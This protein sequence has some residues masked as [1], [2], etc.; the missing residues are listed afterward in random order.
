LKSK[1]AATSNQ[2]DENNQ[3]LY[4]LLVQAEWQLE[5]E[6]L[7]KAEQEF[8]KEKGPLHWKFWRLSQITLDYLLQTVRSSIRLTTSFGCPP[9]NFTKVLSNHLPWNIALARSGTLLAILTDEVIEVRSHKDS[10]CSVVA[11]CQVGTDPFPQWRRITW[12]KQGSLLALA[13]SFGEMSVFDPSCSLLYK[14]KKP[15]ASMNLPTGFNNCLCALFFVDA[16][17]SSEWEFNLICVT[18]HGVLHRYLLNN[19]S[20]R[21]AH[22]F[23]FS[24]YHPAGVAAVVYSLKHNLLVVAGFKGDEPSLDEPEFTGA[25]AGI[26]LWRELSD[27]PHYAIVKTDSKSHE[28]MSKRSRLKG[29]P[30]KAKDIS[31]HG[32]YK[33]VLS[34]NEDTVVTLHQNG[35]IA[36]WRMPSLKLQKTWSLSE[37]PS[38]SIEINS[39][40]LDEKSH[41]DGDAATLENFVNI[42]WWSEEALICARG[43]GSIAVSSI[44]D[45]ENLLGQ[46]EEMF[47]PWPCTTDAS[48][49]QFLVLECEKKIK[50]VGE[51]SILKDAYSEEYDHDD[52]VENFM[53][54]ISKMCQQ[55]LYFL[56]ENDSF[57]PPSKQIRFMQRIYRLVALQSTTPEELYARKINLEEYGEALELAKRFRLDTDL[58]YQRQWTTSPITVISIK[59]Y[60]S[61]INNRFWVLNECV[62]RVPEDI[63]AM[64]YLLKYGLLGTN[65]KIIKSIEMQAFLPFAYSEEQQEV[66]DDDG[67]QESKEAKELCD[68]VSSLK[69]ESLSEKQIQLCR[70]RWQLLQYLDRLETYEIILGGSFKAAERY[71]PDF[72]L[73]FRCCNIIDQSIEYARTSHSEPLEE[74][75]T[76]HGRDVLPHWLAILSNFPETTPVSSYQRLLPFVRESDS[77]ETI[78]EEWK[79]L[80]HREPDWVEADIIKSHVIEQENEDQSAFIYED[81][82]YLCTYRSCNDADLLTKWFIERAHEIESRASLVDNALSLIEHGIEN[83]IQGLEQTRDNLKWLS[84]LAYE[85]NV[86]PAIGLGEFEKLTDLEKLRLLMSKSIE[87]TFVQDYRKWAS[88]FMT[89]VGKTNPESQWKLLKRYLTDVAKS[90]LAFPLKIFEKSVPGCDEPLIADVAKLM[91]LAIDCIYICKRDDQLDLAFKIVECLPSRDDSHLSAQIDDLHDKVDHL[92]H[93]LR[94]SEI[95]KL[96][97]IPKP[98]SFL[99]NTQGDS[100]SARNIFTTL[101]RNASKKIPVLQPKD[102]NLFLKHIQ[103]LREEVYDCVTIKEVYKILVSHI[104]CS[105]IE[106]NLSLAKELLTVTRQKLKEDSHHASASKP[107]RKMPQLTNSSF[108]LPYDDSVS[109]VLD[110]AKEYFNSG[111]N[112][113]DPI[114]DLSR[115]SLSIIE[116]SP[117][118]VQYELDLIAALG[119]LH[120]FDLNILPVQ[121]RLCEDKFDLIRRIATSGSASYRKTAK[122]HKLAKLLHLSSGEEKER[123]GKVTT[124][125]AEAALDCEDFSF[126]KDMCLSLVDL[127]YAPGW[128][129]CRSLCESDKFIDLEAK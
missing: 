68:V 93:Y 78:I 61:K 112:L 39:F 126:A 2:K 10:F 41:I 32:I 105:G 34:P 87:E 84:V 114:L 51:T 79:E 108:V 107:K 15:G 19:T 99:V 58:V 20:Y 94:G 101:C 21:E 95:L 8:W 64:K 38:S 14:I 43:S 96:Y 129:V 119:I 25:R 30:W 97:S 110:A 7:S 65:A 35:R 103:Q 88:R 42:N 71:R 111:A 118:L 36:N 22:A 104:L 122:I 113:I 27:S 83:G 52:D 72:F 47:E 128:N 98:V 29:F 82:P 48:N 123:L 117:P 9:V 53:T 40:L 127:S 86:E 91:I 73:Q 55:T 75:F 106:D 102:W 89:F 74:L 63:D 66:D 46:S 56:T 109:L 18:Y 6:P 26:T 92:E 57:K 49:G 33:C 12:S 50:K 76:Y 62:K 77:D 17:Q 115:K 67:Q 45:L 5:A 31:N 11:K 3:I 59:D 116:D 124:I 85:V 121:V 37:Q 125:L 100:N 54:K 80:K 13:S 81:Q 1:M 69:L 16:V 120:D 28:K 90:D 60:L 24:R 44:K 4:D 70:Y 23:S